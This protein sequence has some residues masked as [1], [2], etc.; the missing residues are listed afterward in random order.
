MSIEVMKQALETL[1]VLWGIIDD[2]DTIGDISRSDDKAYRSLVERKQR[3]RFAKTGITT[4]GYT[5]EGG[6]ITALRQAIKQAEK[7]EAWVGL[8]EEDI[9]EGQKQGWVDKQA[10]E[11]V[12]WWADEKLKE[13]NGH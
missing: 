9:A 8:T 2:I 12:A 4:D 7:Q 13:K 5:L 11:S 3:T 1:D 10:F 6:S